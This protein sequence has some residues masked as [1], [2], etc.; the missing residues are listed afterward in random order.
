MKAAETVIGL[1]LVLLFPQCNGPK[2]IPPVELERC[3]LGR[4]PSQAPG[5]L[6]SAPLRA[7]LPEESDVLAS[8][9]EERRRA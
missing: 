6:P 1:G 5:V 9:T 2:R 4:G 3:A 7:G 8:R